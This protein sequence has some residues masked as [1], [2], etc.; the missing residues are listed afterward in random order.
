MLSHPT[1]QGKDFSFKVGDSMWSQVWCSYH[2]VNIRC[3]TNLKSVGFEAPSAETRLVIPSEV[4][5]NE[6]I[7]VG[8]SWSEGLGKY[9]LTKVI[10]LAPRFI[11]RNDSSKPISFREHGAAP[12]GRPSLEPG[13][14]CPLHFMRMGDEKL[15]TMA[16]T[17][18]NAQ[19]YVFHMLRSACSHED[20]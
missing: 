8:L 9:K 2:A 20:G 3:L 18:L 4:V 6:E 13:E 10:T 11:V 7:H 14:R 17:G 12:R 1:E 16:F 15:L 19:W 5:R